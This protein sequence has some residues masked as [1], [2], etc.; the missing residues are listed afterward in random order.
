MSLAIELDATAK[1]GRDLAKPD[2]N[3]FRFPPPN[4][5]RALRLM[6]T[7]ICL[8]LLAGCQAASSREQPAE[9]LSAGVLTK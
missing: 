9:T 4:P 6:S 3:S 5:P 1:T 7:L 8:M 2:K